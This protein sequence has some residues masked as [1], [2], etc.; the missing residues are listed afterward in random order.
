[1]FR[2][3][4]ELLAVCSAAC[5]T[6]RNP[7]KRSSELLAR[8]VRFFDHPTWSGLGTKAV[9]GLVTLVLAVGGIGF[10]A[11]SRLPSASPN[12]AGAT[13]DAP[14]IE[15]DSVPGQIPE[16]ATIIG[17][18]QQSADWGVWLGIKGTAQGFSYVVSPV[19]WESRTR[20]SA[21]VAVGGVG[22]GDARFKIVAFEMPATWNTFLA[23]L[24][25]YSY[26]GDKGYATM[27]TLAPNAA[28]LT[29][30]EVVRAKGV[31]GT[32]C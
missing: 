15:I 19:S 10:A 23:G 31:P 14:L 8:L 11:G 25:G 32:K 29:S 18:G 7:W 30:I 1:V 12:A 4:G 16:C 26:A 13:A 9:S 27:Q 5:G 2:Q 20:W 24:G 3:D 22:D 17:T 28:A 6:T 21:S